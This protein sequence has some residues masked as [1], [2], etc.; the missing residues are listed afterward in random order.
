MNREI[1]V[2]KNPSKKLLKGSGT[3]VTIKCA[4]IRLSVLRFAKKRKKNTSK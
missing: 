3:D 4:V 1:Q 2:L